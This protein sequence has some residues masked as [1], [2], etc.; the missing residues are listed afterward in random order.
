MICTTPILPNR[1]VE[2]RNEKMKALDKCKDVKE[3][4]SKRLAWTKEDM[5][6]IQRVYPFLFKVS[7]LKLSK[8]LDF[9]LNEAA[10][11][12]DEITKQ[13]PIFSRSLSEINCRFNEYKSLNHRPT[14]TGL[15]C[16]PETYLGRIKKLCQTQKDGM[17]VF[18]LI[19][20]RL[21]ERKTSSKN[22][23][24][25][26][27]IMRHLMFSYSSLRFT[28]KLFWMSI[29]MRMNKDNWSKLMLRHA[30]SFDESN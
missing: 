14:M 3:Y 27:F 2:E 16:T 26:D 19:E 4:L 24:W 8:M 30:L 13:I 29:K 6:N 21:H 5:E 12:A 15:R 7:I 10:Y 20:S 25:L 17:A 1:M 11:T 22:K 23:N 28:M 9:L 18:K